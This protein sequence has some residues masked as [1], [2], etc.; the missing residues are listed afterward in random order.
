MT[1]CAVV[2]SVRTRNNINKKPNLYSLLQECIS[3]KN[4]EAKYHEIFKYYFPK[5]EINSPFRTDGILKDPD[6]GLK[7]LIETKFLVDLNDR[8]ERNKLI[9]QALYYLKKLERLGEELPTILFFGDKDECFYIHTNTLLPLLN[10]NL[11]W[12]LSPSI[13]PFKNAELLNSDIVT[14][15]VE[16]I[17]NDHFDFNI[18][19]EKI[20][21]LH[22][23][24]IQ[25]I[26]ITEL[27][28]NRFFNYFKD[29]VLIEKK[30]YDANKL[31]SI[32]L[33][34][35]IDSENNYLHPK[36][37]NILVSTID[38][39]IRVN[40]ENFKAFFEKFEAE[41][42]IPEKQRLTAICDR[43]IADE[44]RRFRGEF[45]T[46]TDWVLDAHK[47]I[48]KFD[49]NWKEE[50]VVWD[51]SWGTGNLTRDFKF[52]ALYCST[53][54]H[55]DLEIGR[56]YNPEAIKF[57]YD[58][59]NDDVT[60]DGLLPV[61]GI[62]KLP[63]GLYKAM[64]LDK[65]NILFFFNPP[66]GKSSGN[67]SGHVKAKKDLGVSRINEEMIRNNLGKPS[68]Q[69]YAQFLYRIIQ[70]QKVNKNICLAFFSPTLFL[71]G[72][73]YK[74]FREEFLKHFCFQSGFIFNAGHFSGVSE[75]WS[76]MFSVWAPGKNT[77]KF[78]VD[79]KDYDENGIIR[80]FGK[81]EL[82]NTDGLLPANKWCRYEGKRIDSPQL[83]GPLNVRQIGGS[84]VCEN[85]I[86]Y[87]NCSSNN[88]Y[89]NQI[90]VDF[91]SSGFGGGVGTGG[92]PGFPVTE[93]NFMKCISLFTA[94]KTITPNWIN[95]KDE[96][97]APNTEHPEYAQWNQ[98]AIIYSLFSNQSSL[99]K[100][101]YKDKLWDIKNEFFWMSNAHM[102][103]LA[104]KYKFDELYHDAKGDHDRFVFKKL[105]EV[106]ISEDAAQVLM[107]AIEL[108]EKTF[109]YR[110]DLH[111]E[112]PEWH[113]HAWDAGWYQIKLILKKILP[114]DL[115]EFRE[116]YKKFEDRMREGVYKFGFL[117]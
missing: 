55:S 82:Y 1:V 50:Y 84:R 104:E 18:I 53:L 28:I 113:L 102:L 109:P 99:R 54:H 86:T 37:K 116:L 70:L 19:V 45:F 77:N 75:S 34:C 11:D 9:I 35:I 76:I 36:K 85:F 10:L 97:L 80:S 117:K 52:E 112:H 21:Q 61:D 32:F 60:P 23:G 62:K 74:K 25:K 49:S 13:A 92:A 94:R 78:I 64:Y 7:V 30:K 105:Q 96:Y 17:N 15:F 63:D 47:L 57:H 14:P 56:N 26:R 42:T 69:L 16:H 90:L 107:K 29:R 5:A 59:L 20:I 67:F 79:I 43:L 93:K 68:G 110:K 38:D 33:G 12:S 41:Y 83:A 108:V 8:I 100:V 2:S 71:T 89:C 46:P 115:K 81:K 40:S 72:S 6:T 58:F 48:E 73:S 4:V 91:Y 44:A 103:N 51:P 106:T 66:F 87:F 22:Q 111:D 88:V 114:D 39:N 24:T 101:T 95:Q 65:R 27:N 98:D 3:E 31:V